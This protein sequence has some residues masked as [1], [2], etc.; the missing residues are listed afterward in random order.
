MADDSPQIS[1]FDRPEDVVARLGGRRWPDPESVPHNAGRNKVSEQVLR[2]LRAAEQPLLVVG[3]ASLDRLLDFLAEEPRPGRRVRILFGAEPFPSREVSF[4]FRGGFPEEVRRY[5]ERQGVSLR[6][7]GAII[8]V[9]ERL[10]AGEI[11]ARYVDGARLHAKLYCTEA[12]VTLGSSNFTAGGLSRNLEANARFTAGESR[13]REIWQLAENYWASARD[14][15]S[16]LCRLL[17]AML[18]FVG[19]REALLR[20][21]TELLEGEWAEQY[22]RM[23]GYA[24]ELPLWPSQRQG[25]ARALWVIQNAGSVLVADATGSGKTRM[26][27]HLVRSVMDRIWSHQRIRKG[28]PLLV[29]PP[30]VQETWRD[31][32]RECS[33]P[34]LTESHGQLS[35]GGGDAGSSIQDQVRRAQ[36]LAVDEAHNFLNARSRR[37]R[38]LLNNMADHT[39]LFTATPIN[40]SAQDLLRLVDMLG[41]DNLDPDTLKRFE[42]ML[43][44]ERVDRTLSR[45]ELAL[46]RREIRRFTVRRTKAEL[47]RMIDRDPDAYRNAYG[48]RC[49][50]PEHRS[51]LYALEETAADRDRARQIRELADQLCGVAY[52]HRRI[53]MPGVLRQE[54]WSEEKYLASRLSA[55]RKLPAYIV[56][57]ALRSSRAALLE[58]IRGTVH[59][60]EAFGLEATL[61]K[62]PT[63]DVLS[64]LAELAGRPPENGLR[65]PLPDWLTDPERHRAACETDRRIYREI[66]ALVLAMSDA[67]E[68][69]KATFLQTLLRS[70]GLLV[71][72]DSRPVTLALMQRLLAGAA[73]AKSILAS[74]S[75]ARGRGEVNQRFRLGSADRGIV[76]LCSDSMAEG[77]NLQQAGCM[78]H[79]DMPSV[80]RVAEQRVGR[81]DRMDSPHERIDVWWPKD[82]PEFALRADERF[83]ERYE[84]VEALIGANMPLPE[85][86]AD[87]HR[88]AVDAEQQVQRIE[89]SL[90]AEAS[91]DGIEDAFSSVRRLIQGPSAL[92]D[93]EAGEARTPDGDEVSSRVCLVRS[94][95]SWAFFCLGGTGAQAPNWLMF[96]AGGGGPLTDLAAVSG[97]LREALAENPEDVPFD[98]GAADWLNRFIDR[99]PAA[100]RQMLP[101]KKQKALAEME[102]VLDHYRHEAALAQRQSELEACDH[103]L[104]ALRHPDP[105]APPDWDALAE[106][107]LDL[108][109]PVWYRKLTEGRRRRRPLLLRDLRRDLTGADRIPPERIIE[110]VQGIGTLPALERRVRAAIIGVPE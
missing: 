71:A 67:R 84:T 10:A 16:E 83:I 42:R 50:Y 18:R 19:W 80:V 33:L 12:A 6:L 97:A 78:V 30:A 68:R 55:A 61:H 51:R 45:E 8:A 13:F 107:W 95:R 20:A 108:I 62:T 24:R 15:G 46:L 79:L 48:E 88:E 40:R 14:Y 29:C 59:A 52:L 5:W 99:L 104:D 43:R 53:Q 35:R 11:E 36:V 74:G 38:A 49:R 69:R 94:E 75:E 73:G 100:Q 70:H 25:I 3:Y 77:I 89:E 21:C 90:N 64:T 110:A 2:D 63:G 34:L 31:E 44:R 87:T 82:A 109:R 37:T 41:A 26:G 66:E 28:Q 72:F 57:A 17:E 81:V 7:C 96:P 4:P 60:A 27:A 85:G 102:H 76:A 1:L 9:L 103:L 105:E 54:G 93:A 47:N 98:R 23:Q 32:A 22:L 92:V 58:H 65:I 39:V 91:W 101:L 56:M 106:T 86:M